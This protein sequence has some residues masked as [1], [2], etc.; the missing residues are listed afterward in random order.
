MGIRD[1]AVKLFDWIV[2]GTGHGTTELARRLRIPEQEL[3]TV[4]PVY[5]AFSIPKRSGGIRQNSCPGTPV[6]AGPETPFKASFCEVVSPSCRHG[7]RTWMFDRHQCSNPSGSGCCPA[8][9]FDRFFQLHFHKTFKKILSKIG[10]NR[11]ASQLLLRL[12]TGQGGLPQ[13]APT[14]PRLSNL[15]N[16]RLDA[17]LAGLI[18]KLGGLY[19]RYADDI[20][21]SFATQGLHAAGKSDFPARNSAD[22]T[23]N[24]PA[25]TPTGQDTIRSVTRAVRK[26]VETEGYRM[27]HRKKLSVRRQHQQQ[28]VTGLVVNQRVNLPRSTRRWLR[29]VE[30]RTQMSQPI[31]LTSYQPGSY[32]RRKSPTLSPAQLEGWRSFRAM[33]QRQAVED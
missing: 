6:E 32:S 9:R 1:P 30:Y 25:Q 19:T 15:L 8:I 20:T 4:E 7:V 24:H 5:H 13:G 18:T 16:Y 27:H 2:N 33:V 11:T 3:R 10:W 14:S 28:V 21:I 22:D 23:S 29:A 26:V 31:S 17:R 12:C